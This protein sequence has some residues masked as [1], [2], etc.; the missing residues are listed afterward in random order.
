[1]SE[2]IDVY[3][4][5]KNGIGPF[6]S[7]PSEWDKRLK[8][9]ISC[10]HPTP[11]FDSGFDRDW[12]DTVEWEGKYKFGSPSRESLRQWIRKPQVLSELGFKVSLY[13]AKKKYTH[14]SEIQTMFIK[15]HAKKI[16]EWNVEE[17]CTGNI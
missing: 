1:M 11:W 13:K 10:N 16:K 9:C 6:R 7:F 5:E 12:L 8:G 17:F 4:I 2:Y 3:R 14:S 15:R